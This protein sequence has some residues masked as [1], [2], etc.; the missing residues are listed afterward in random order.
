MNIKKLNL[1]LLL[2]VFVGC[3]GQPSSIE[4]KYPNTVVLEER[5]ANNNL[6]RPTV[7]TPTVDNLFNTRIEMVD[8]SNSEISSYPKVQTWNSNMTLM[9][10]G[11]RLYDAKTLKES[12]YTKNSSKPYE[13]LCSRSSDYFRWSNNDSDRF[14]VLDSSKRFIQGQINQNNISCSNVLESFSDYEKVHI[15]PHEG[16]I[17]YN[18]K[19]ILF[20]AKKEN[21]TTIYLILFDIAN[22]TRVWTK[23]LPDDKWIYDQGSD[24]WEPAVMD[25]ISVSPSGKYIVINNRAKANYSEGLSRYDIDFNNHAFLRYNYNGSIHSEGGHG[26]MGYDQENHEVIV[27][28]LAGLGVYSF[29]LDNPDEL[30]KRL[31]GSPYGGGHVS[32]RNTKRKGWCYITANVDSN[33]NGLRRIFALKLDG[34]G[35]ENVEN[36]SQTYIDDDFGNTFG[37]ASPDG[38]KIIFNSHWNSENLDTFVVEAK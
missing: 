34:S 38:T 16:N 15:G 14:F 37:G 19:Y 33:Q 29:N 7:N 2:G 31:L 27:G 25:W 5:V 1:M 11:S 28:F 26:D 35:E 32:C 30:G 8:K 22:Q 21:D 9:R 17:D 4:K 3:G 23:S 24:S 10:V 12:H 36:F 6:S 20:S 13:T 18:D